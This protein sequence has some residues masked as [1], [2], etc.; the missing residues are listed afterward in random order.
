MS[1]KAGFI[2]CLY[3]W[4]SKKDKKGLIPSEVKVFDYPEGFPFPNPL[5]QKPGRYYHILTDEDG[6]RPVHESQV[7]FLKG[8]PKITHVVKV[9]FEG[10]P[11]KTSK[12]RPDPVPPKEPSQATQAIQAKIKEAFTSKPKT[13]KKTKIV[14]PSPPVESPPVEPKPKTPSKKKK[15]PKP[16]WRSAFTKKKDTPKAKAKGEP[17]AKSKPKPKPKIKPQAKVAKP[18]EKAKAKTKPVPKIKSKPKAQAKVKEVPKSKS[19]AKSNKPKPSTSPRTKAKSPVK[20]KPKPQ[21]KV[22]TPPKIKTKP[23]KKAKP[24]PKKKRSVVEKTVHRLGKDSY[25]EFDKSISEEQLD[26]FMDWLNPT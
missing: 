9:G 11:T 6:Y 3:R 7:T 18:K 25:I 26:Q 1:N 16:D 5:E 12:V 8:E 14:E 21:P 10:T 20:A 4:G 13:S 2:D 24:Q 23:K 15:D 22:A 17:Q 19:P